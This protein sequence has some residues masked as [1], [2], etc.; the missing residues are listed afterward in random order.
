MKIELK[1]D[2]NEYNIK[3]AGG[4]D[5]KSTE[6]LRSAF[7]EVAGQLPSRVR[8]DLKS[9]PTINSSGLGKILLLYENLGQSQCSLEI[10]AVSD[11]LLE[12]FRLVRLDKIISIRR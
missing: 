8:L 6:R 12:V 9:V 11:N 5:G 2:N 1:K 3:I 7:E 4:I 10:S